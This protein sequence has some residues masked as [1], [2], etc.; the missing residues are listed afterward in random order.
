MDRGHGGLGDVADGTDRSTGRQAMIISVINHTP[1]PDA[2]V[3]EAIRAI[4]RQISDDFAV[5]WSIGATLRLEGKSTAKPET[6][7]LRDMRGQA[8]IYLWNGKDPEGALG[9]HEANNRGIPFGF[10]F[11][12]LSKTLH[13]SWTT[14]LSHEALEMLA[15]PEVN[16]L[17]RGP[18]PSEKGKYVFHWYEMCDAVQDETYEIDGVA[19]S[20][21]LLPLYFTGQD[22][23][24]GRN[25]F[26]GTLIKKKG[27]AA[28][29]ISSFGINPGGYIGFFNPETGEDETATLKGDRRA[30]ARLAAKRR[31]RGGRRSTR[32]QR[33]DEA[34]A[35]VTRRAAATTIGPRPT[36]V[37]CPGG[38]T[39]AAPPATPSPRGGK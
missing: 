13:E 19:V 39:I 22:E 16:L 32:Y 18:H 37:P 2:K 29:T 1:I 20:N 35:G 27:A 9:Y 12:Q 3:Q 21:F 34:A 38:V 14:T 8:V 4:N 15:D 28:R 33:F 17:V 30:Q 23:G 6:Q 31:Y 7:E 24:G 36:F 26:L 25:D 10:V 5:Y 11:T